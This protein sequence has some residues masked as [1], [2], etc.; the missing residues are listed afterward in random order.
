MVDYQRK[1]SATR[2]VV[3]FFYQVVVYQLQQ[4]IAHPEANK[5]PAPL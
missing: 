4:P 5:P 1:S 2:N 3:S